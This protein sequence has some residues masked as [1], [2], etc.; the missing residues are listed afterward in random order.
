MKERICIGVATRK[1][2][3]MFARLLDSLADLNRPDGV[4]LQFVFV[5]NDDVLHIDEIVKDFAERL[6]PEETSYV[7]TEPRLGIPMVRNRILDTALDMQSDYLASIDDDEIADVDWLVRLYSE[8][9][10]RKLDLVGGVKRMEE[11]DASNLKMFQKLIYRDLL[12]RQEKSERS[13][14]DRHASGRDGAM[15]IDTGNML[16]RLDFI[17]RN[18]IRFDEAFR[19]SHGEDYDFYVQ[20]KDAGGA[21]GYAPHALVHEIVH[22]NRLSPLFQFQQSRSVARADY[23]IRYKKRGNREWVRST[24]VVLWRMVLG[25]SRVLCSCFNRGRSFGRGIKRI[26]TAIGRLEAMLGVQGNHYEH[27]DGH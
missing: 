2:P 9:K 11:I 5:E 6:D 12:V 18:Q 13:K 17:C 25:C 26:A 3:V 23:S 14:A 4:L 22:V 21:T 7:D 8:A 1:R 10:T 24:C 20:I 19:L 15:M 27:T 16:C